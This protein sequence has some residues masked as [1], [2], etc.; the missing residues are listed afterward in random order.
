AWSFG[1]STTGSGATPTHIYATPG[2]FTIT[3]T[4]TDNSLSTGSAS[5]VIVVTQPTGAHASLINWQAEAK[6][7]KISLKNSGGEAFY[8]WGNNTGTYAVYVYVRF[9]LTLD[10]GASQ[11]VYTQLVQ[12]LPGQSING[13]QDARFSAIYLPTAAGVVTVTATIYYSIVNAP[14]GNSVYLADLSTSKSFTFRVT[15]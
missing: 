2:T 6:P 3:L 7:P 13:K 8:A 9:H 4:V 12:L 14:I 5:T 10:T 15:P 1:D 11:D